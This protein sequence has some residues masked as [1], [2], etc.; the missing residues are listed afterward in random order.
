MQ[1]KLILRATET[2]RVLVKTET[3]KSQEVRFPHSFSDF[4]GP[5]VQF[6]GVYAIFIT[7]IVFHRYESQITDQHDEELH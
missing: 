5:Y 6:I 3:V 2:R 4:S 7:Y 1:F